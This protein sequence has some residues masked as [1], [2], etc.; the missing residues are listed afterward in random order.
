MKLGVFEKI[1]GRLPADSPRR[2][3]LAQFDGRF[4]CEENKLQRLMS[5]IIGV[6]L[7]QGDVDHLY[8]DQRLQ[9]YFSKMAQEFYQSLFG[10]FYIANKARIDEMLV[11][12]EEFMTKADINDSEYHG[13]IALQVG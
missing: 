12:V 7:Y 6:A 5:V 2:E 1:H 3:K 9:P 4:D 10:A 13:Q 8:L 11:S